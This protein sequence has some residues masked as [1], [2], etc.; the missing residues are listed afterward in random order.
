MV[1]YKNDDNDDKPNDDD[2]HGDGYRTVAL[3][4]YN[5]FPVKQPLTK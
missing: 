2:D 4:M 3:H 1:F 5:V